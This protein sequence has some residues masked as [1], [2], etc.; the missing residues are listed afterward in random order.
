MITLGSLALGNKQP[1]IAAVVDSL[2]PV[3]DLVVLKQEGVD[4]LEIRVDLFDVP[5]PRII[6]YLCDLHELVGLPF[7]GTVRE[8]ARTAAQRGLIFAAIMPFVD[9]ID[10]ELGSP[11]EQ[12]VRT[13]ARL[14]KVKV[15]VSEHNFEGMPDDAALQNI[16][17]RAVAQGGDIVKIAAA[18]VTEG[19]AWRLLR[20]VERCVTPIVAFAMGEAG[21]FSR[22]KACEYGSLFT[23]GY[24]TKPVAPG[25]MSARELAG[26]MKA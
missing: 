12:R 14:H 16:V 17:D 2:V 4:L 25:Q 10:I 26:K 22:V 5:V 18:A 9:C 11:I 7:I 8:N 13:E 23:Y 24:V 21:A 20:F 1:R 3:D 19:D 15:M 6:K